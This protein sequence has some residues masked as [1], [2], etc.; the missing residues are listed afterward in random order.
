MFGFTLDASDPRSAARLGRLRT[1]HGL[2][3]TPAFMAVGTRGAI[4]GVTPDQLRQTGTQIM[5]CNTYHLHVR[6]G[7][8]CIAH[9][10]GLHRFSGW[11]GPLLTDSGG[12]QVFSLAHINRITDEG[13]AFQSH[14][15]GAPMFLDPGTAMRVQEQLGADITMAFDQCPALPSPPET[16]ARAV[17][18]TLRW[19]EECK[20]ARRREDQW[21]FGIV[22]GGLDLDLRGRCAERVVEMGF[23]GYAIGG[24][25]VGET[26]AQMIAVLGGLAGALPADRPRYLMGVGTPRD[27][28]ESV[29]LGVDMFD[30]VLP[31][32]NGRNAHVF[33]ATG[34]LKLRNHRHRMAEAPIEAA[35]DCYACRHFSRAYLRHLFITGEMLG[36]IL[37]SIHNLRFFQ[38]LLAR[39]RDLIREGRLERISDEF[40]VVRADAAEPMS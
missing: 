7:A 27:I 6:P 40:P 3:E 29:R 8:D 39:I 13:V 21:L 32:R 4:K 10:G 38:R 37:A 11:T 25:S 33:T 16:I 2:V 35:C 18:R 34:F 17:E 24:L 1:P 9:L 36:P 14:F 31:T 5:L 22:Q 26:H 30:C 20:R 12:F 23:D 19:A 28:L 15:D